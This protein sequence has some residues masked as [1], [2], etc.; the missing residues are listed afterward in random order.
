MTSTPELDAA[1]K[2]ADLKKAAFQK[3]LNELKV[4]GSA[5]AGECLKVPDPGIPACIVNGDSGRK[6][7]EAGWTTLDMNMTKAASLAVAYEP[8]PPPPPPDPTPS[9]VY[10]CPAALE[11]TLLKWVFKPVDGA[12]RPTKDGSIYD[13][14][15]DYKAGATL[16]GFKM[17]STQSGFYAGSQGVA[18]GQKGVAEDITIKNAILEKLDKWHHRPHKVRKNLRVSFVSDLLGPSEHDDYIEPIGGAGLWELC[19]LRQNCYSYRAGSQVFQLAQRERDGI[20]LAEYIDGGMIILRNNKAVDHARHSLEGGTGTR[21]SQAWKAFSA[22]GGPDEAHSYNRVLKH[23]LLFKDL[24]LDDTMQ[25]Y[26]H[27]AFLIGACYGAV[28]LGGDFRMGSL[29]HLEGKTIEGVRVESFITPNPSG[30]LLIDGANF[31]ATSGEGGPGIAL[32]DDRPVK[33]INVTGN[34]RVQD[35]AGKTIT[36]ARNGYEKNWSSAAQATVDKIIAAGAA[37]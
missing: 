29:S 21:T 4:S 16:Q 30:P 1:I 10:G 7:L 5:L 2:D 19:Y 12:G 13:L 3:A 32:L 9:L 14:I 17:T 34:F 37:L 8:P 27:G 11:P 28:I 24:L 26:S 6:Q 35:A 20:T 36:L 25:K 23:H 15:P 31:E 33:I 18:S 22:Q